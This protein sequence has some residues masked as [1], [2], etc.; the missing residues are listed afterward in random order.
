MIFGM[1][2][3]EERLRAEDATAVKDEALKQ[4]A[5]IHGQLDDARNSGL[6]PDDYARSDTLVSALAAARAILAPFPLYKEF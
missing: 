2:E 3:L 1:T 6:A 4:L 5:T